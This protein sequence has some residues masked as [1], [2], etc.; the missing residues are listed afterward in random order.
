MSGRLSNN[1]G[2]QWVFTDPGTP[3]ASWGETQSGS[4]HVI[5]IVSESTGEIIYRTDGSYPVISLSD[6]PGATLIIRKYDRR[7]ME[8]V[9]ESRVSV[10]AAGD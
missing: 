8:Q 5:E 10:L 2:Q 7:T 9:D 1:P 3:L 4:A 6:M